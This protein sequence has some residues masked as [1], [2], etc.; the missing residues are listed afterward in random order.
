MIKSNGSVFI[1]ETKKSSYVFHKNNEGLLVHDYYG[2]LITLDGYDVKPIQQKLSVAKG[3]AT[4]Y[5]DGDDAYSMDTTL[6]EFSFPH[7]GDYKVTPI[8]LK[9]D[10]YGY[11]FDFTF[12]RFEISG[13]IAKVEGLP[14]PHKGDSELIIYLKDK[15]TDINIEL[16][17][18]VFEENNAIARY[19]I[20]KNA[21]KEELHV[22]KAL[23]YQLDLVNDQYQLL[24]FTGGW[25]TEMNE[26]LIDLK[27][28][29]Y[30]HESRTGN[31]SS[32][33]N[34]FF[35]LKNKDASLEYGDVYAFN[36]MYSGNHIYEV[37][38]ST[39]GLVR[40]EA[41]INPFCFDFTLKNE[42][43]FVTPVAILSYSKDGYNGIRKNM[44]G[45][46]NEHVVPETWNHRL[47]P[48]VINNWEA[49]YFRFNERKILSVAK[50]GKSIGAELMVLDD[51]WF[52]VRDNDKGGLGD[53]DVNRKKLPH[54]LNGL[55][56]KI[57]KLG[58]KFGLWF[59]PESVNPV[60]SLYEAHP[61]WAIKNSDRDPALGRNQ[62]LLDLTQKEVRDYIIE[63]VS[64]TL[65]GANIEYVKWDMNRNMSDIP[66]FGA[67]EFYHRYILGLYE[68]M[69]VLTKKFP[70]VL[71]E[72]CASGGNRFD[73][74][75]L[76][77]FPQIWA[78]DDTDAIERRRIQ[79]SYSYG[80]PLS[81]LS[82]HVSCVP[83]H[84][85]LRNTPIDTRFNVAMFGVLGY[86]LLP[87]EMPK[88]DF[89]RV[90]ELI[91]V[92]KDFREI[93]QFGEFDIL[94]DDDTQ[95]TQWQVTNSEKTRAIFG[96]F[97]DLQ[98][99]N[100]QED[101]LKAK[102]LLE[103]KIYTI[104]NVKDEVDIIRFGG[105]VNTML[106]FHVNPNGKMMKFMARRIHMDADID[107]YE[108]YGNVLNN[109]G[110]LLNPQWSASGFSSGVRVLGDF[111][112]RIYIA[113]IKGNN[114]A[115]E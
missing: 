111:G 61:D 107:D 4:M 82:N 5:K 26:Q 2:A 108:A 52:G 86:E 18:I 15:N 90:K 44:H 17:Y 33:V 109:K 76:S 101:I 43:K 83:S 93:F 3:T 28:G 89:K 113:A 112:S 78:S 50:Q 87:K 49:T 95:L 73:L 10:A 36:L 21:T 99:L 47:R 8:L 106:P 60:S 79:R 42:D 71:F 45:F 35:I 98:V 63:S 54:G 40:V 37:E 41:G 19:M 30:V 94:Q 69:D 72:G 81:C 57:N 88:K 14:S 6:L 20:I 68:I 84:Q 85:M 66:S 80:Y 100:I 23:S 29:T 25:A 92:Y 53:Y 104:N 48:V 75:I 105:L 34:P 38:L 22:L 59:E 9:N 24:S 77:Y 110:L 1:L 74:G 97:N 114:L 91:Q 96:H 46:V 7:K 31:S 56:K 62:L 103:D 16:H 55:A 65:E 11:V 12:E 102:G 51:G 58:M 13:E 115:Q 64:K 39:Y 27:V 67:G 70:D 32:R